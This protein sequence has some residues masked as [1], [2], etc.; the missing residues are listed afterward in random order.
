M[1]ILQRGIITYNLKGKRVWLWSFY[2][3][4]D[5]LCEAQGLLFFFFFRWRLISESFTGDLDTCLLSPGSWR[6]QHDQSYF[7]FA[8]F[9]SPRDKFADD[10]LCPFV[11]ELQNAMTK[12]ACCWSKTANFAVCDIRSCWKY[13]N[14]FKWSAV[15][16]ELENWVPV[17]EKRPRNRRHALQRLPSHQGNIIQLAHTFIQES[18]TTTIKYTES[19]KD[20]QLVIPFVQPG[21]G[22]K[23]LYFFGERVWIPL[24]SE[25]VWNPA[26]CVFVPDIHPPWTWMLG[27]FESL[28]RNAC[29]QTATWFI[30]STERVLREWSQNPC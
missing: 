14:Q 1:I 6:C 30:L 13:S 25:P 12:K 5:W 10:Q 21:K 9:G 2:K 27:S 28:R 16:R 7:P 17:A 19:L 26:R 15:P 18:E 23:T 8:T 11:F 29:E 22:M 3:R 24:T 20:W 4:Y